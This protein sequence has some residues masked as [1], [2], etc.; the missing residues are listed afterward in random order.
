MIFHKR[1]IFQNMTKN[2]HNYR[3]VTMWGAAH[4][5]PLGDQV[6]GA[7][8]TALGALL[9]VCG[10]NGM[11]YAKMRGRTK[12]WALALCLWASGQ[13]VFILASYFATVSV[14]A[15][16]ANFAIPF[17]A[18]IASR[19][20]DETFRCR[21]RRGAS[22][23]RALF[24]WDLLGMACIGAGAV[25]TVLYA[26]APPDGVVSYSAEAE[27]AMLRRPL[28][29]TVLVLVGPGVLLAAAPMT[30]CGGG[31]RE[32]SV[33]TPASCGTRPI[34]R[35]IAYGLICGAM[36]AQ[37]FVSTKLMLSC[38]RYFVDAF[39]YALGAWAA[40]CE[41]IMVASLNRSLVALPKSSVV[42]ISTYYISSTIFSSVVGMSTFDLFASF[43]GGGAVALFLFGALLCIIGVWIVSSGRDGEGEECR[44]EAQGEGEGYAA[45]TFS[46]A[47]TI[48]AADEDDRDRA[49]FFQAPLLS[50]RV[51]QSLA[52]ATQGR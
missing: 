49:D 21:L 47:K 10:L 13:A 43:G 41:L 44:E 12:P 24:E 51:E 18:M 14:C 9:T 22:W 2:V 17:N 32:K 31:H 15:A 23:R 11:K 34:N 39:W 19:F 50:G 8:L 25:V 52:Y 37:T 45:R 30:W 26:P 46:T 35:A 6:L 38:D 1:I 20:F 42:I 29:L 28:A 40:V 5:P 4:H 48:P 33:A 7:C 3:Q 27:E 36:G 16:A